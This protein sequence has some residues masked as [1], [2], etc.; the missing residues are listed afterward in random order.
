MTPPIPD[1]H[2]PPGPPHKGRRFVDWR[3]LQLH[4][5]ILLLV[6]IAVLGYQFIYRLT[7][8]D[9][10]MKSNVIEPLPSINQP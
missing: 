4:W 9:L 6:V 10:A 2:T 3:Q 7:A 8:L 1:P 5:W